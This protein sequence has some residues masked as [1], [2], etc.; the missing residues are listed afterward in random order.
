MTFSYLGKP[1]QH[2]SITTDIDKEKEPRSTGITWLNLRLQYLSHFDI[3][4]IASCAK[5]RF[6]L[7]LVSMTTPECSGYTMK[8]KSWQ[9]VFGQEEEKRWCGLRLYIYS[10]R[11]N[12]KYQA[13]CDYQKHDCMSWQIVIFHVGFVIRVPIKCTSH[14]LQRCFNTTCKNRSLII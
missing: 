3:P 7:N 12:G 2:P 4:I 9:N 11:F 10:H 8:I 13:K 5:V 1:C 14:R 6:V